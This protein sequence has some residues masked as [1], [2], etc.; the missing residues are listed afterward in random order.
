M[1][2]LHRLSLTSNSTWR[3]STA[4]RSLPALSVQL[5][6]QLL[7]LLFARCSW[8]NGELKTR[9][10]RPFHRFH[11]FAVESAEEGR[12]LHASGELDRLVDDIIEPPVSIKL[13]IARYNA[14]AR[15]HDDPDILS[16]NPLPF[17]SAA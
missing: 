14:I 12:A 6:H 7:E 16:D 9:F 10:K 4:H 13:L 15:L 8:A 3:G 17:A 2:R 5:E 11:R 1:N